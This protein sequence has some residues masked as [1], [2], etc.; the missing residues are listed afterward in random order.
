MERLHIIK[1]IILYAVKKLLD[2]NLIEFFSLFIFVIMHLT[3]YLFTN[4]IKVEE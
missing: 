3:V 2:T 4:F 1:L